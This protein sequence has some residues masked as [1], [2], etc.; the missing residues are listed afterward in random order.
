MDSVEQVILLVS[1]KPFESR[2]VV[3]VKFLFIVLKEFKKR[4]SQ[5]FQRLFGGFWE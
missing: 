3:V 5:H 4:S 1:D 2:V